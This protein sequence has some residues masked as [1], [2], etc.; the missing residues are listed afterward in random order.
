[1]SLIALAVAVILI[2]TALP[3][4]RNLT[5]ATLALSYFGNP[6]VIPGLLIM[7]SMVIYKQLKYI[8]NQRLGFD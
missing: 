1:M 8:Q 4:Y 2:Q 3:F 6:F 5:G 7:G